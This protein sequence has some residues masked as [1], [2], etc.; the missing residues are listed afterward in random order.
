MAATDQTYRSQRAL[1]IVFGVSSLLMLVSIV[2]MFMQDYNRPWKTEQRVFLK[3]ES[4]AAQRDALDQVFQITDRY[5][6]AMLKVDKALH[7]R[8]QNEKRIEELDAEIREL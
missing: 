1:D 6:E 5:D 4:V 7:K 2:L 8:R 3:V